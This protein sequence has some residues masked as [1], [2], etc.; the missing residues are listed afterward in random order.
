[1]MAR[2]ASRSSTVRD[3]VEQARQIATEGHR[4]I[5][6]SGVNIGLFGSDN[7]ESLLELLRQLDRVDGVDRFRISSI[8]PNLLT[9]SII[10]FVAGS[11][12]F[13][14][15]FHIPLQSGDDFVLGRMRRRY[16]ASRYASRIETIRKRIPDA[17]I[18]A[19]VIVGFPAESRDRFENSQRFVADLPVSYLH[20]F[21]YSERKGTAAVDDI[22]GMGAHVVPKAERTRR[23][24]V[25]RLLSDRKKTEFAKQNLG[26]LRPV[27]WEA[28]TVAGLTVG[29][30]DNYIRVGTRSGSVTEGSIERVVLDRLD[31]TGI[32][33][34]APAE[35]VP[36]T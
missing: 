36:I 15:H 9:D 22:R 25:L 34:S 6:L 4:E 32:V 19:D 2:G 11:R 27:L 21:T 5:V 16:R 28:K 7:G 30:T 31:E 8:E 33:V 17:G 26:R 1:P 10:D 29:F 23:N 12:R 14:P 24:R 13:M 18:G 20:V 35:F 3:A